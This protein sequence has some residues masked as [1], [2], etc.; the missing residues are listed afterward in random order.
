MRSLRS[1]VSNREDRSRTSFSSL[2][3]WRH[4]LYQPSQDSRNLQT[5]TRRSDQS[6][7]KRENP[8]NLRVEGYRN[9]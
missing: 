4:N 7:D 6:A 1:S 5:R 9:V 8:N 2:K 3:N